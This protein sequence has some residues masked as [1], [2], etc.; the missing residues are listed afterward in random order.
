MPSNYD[1]IPTKPSRETLLQCFS[2]TSS[3]YNLSFWNISFW[4]SRITCRS[5]Q[6]I[7][8]YRGF[9]KSLAPAWT[10][11]S[12]LPRGRQFVM[13]GMQVSTVTAR[14]SNTLLIK[15]AHVARLANRHSCVTAGAQ[16]AWKCCS[17]LH[18]TELIIYQR[19]APVLTFS[20]PPSSQQAMVSFFHP[21]ELKE[22][23][24]DSKYWCNERKKA[25]PKFQYRRLSAFTAQ[26][27]C[28][29]AWQPG[30]SAP[31][32]PVIHY[33]RPGGWCKQ[34]TL[35]CVDSG[36]RALYTAVELRCFTLTHIIYSG[37]TNGRVH[38]E[39][40]PN[41]TD[42]IQQWCGRVMRLDLAGIKSFVNVRQAQLWMACRLKW[43]HT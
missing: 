1:D 29:E 33:P 5:V 35:G 12:I 26:A 36:P 24:S 10:V 38:R 18:P 32:S 31:Q 6:H 7:N 25:K 8:I 16:I 13:L 17:W 4:R 14:I 43:L 40:G 9:W 30:C 27:T 42:F 19:G 22:E 23:K 15:S 39:R 21:R 2:V 3:S 28:F 34:E 37:V 41:D 11:R 20:N